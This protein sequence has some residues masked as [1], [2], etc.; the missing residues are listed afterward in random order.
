[1]GGGA[2]RF[3]NLILKISFKKNCQQPPQSS[4]T[5]SYND[6][7]PRG[8]PWQ[9]NYQQQ[10]NINRQQSFYQNQQKFN[11]KQ[12][13]TSKSSRPLADINTVPTKRGKWV[14]VDDNE[15]N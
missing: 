3:L 11:G 2:A 5:N 7:L 15:G 9:P 14:W 6:Y 12:Q 13:Q 10:N 4:H 1:V 8:R